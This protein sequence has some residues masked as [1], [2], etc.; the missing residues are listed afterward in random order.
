MPLLSLPPPLQEFPGFLSRA[1]PGS[2]PK[3]LATCFLNGRDV[4]AYHGKELLEVSGKDHLGGAPQFPAQILE[5][6]NSVQ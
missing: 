5:D 3:T 1:V 4:A 6:L 2:K